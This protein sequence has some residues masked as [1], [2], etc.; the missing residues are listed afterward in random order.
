MGRIKKGAVEKNTTQTRVKSY[1]EILA[2]SGEVRFSYKYLDVSHAKF[3]IECQSPDYFIKLIDRLANV[4]RMTVNE[5]RQ[6]RNNKSMR[7]HS[8]K[9]PEVTEDNFGIPN[10]DEIVTEPWQFS[11]TT[12]EHG[13]IHGFIIGNTFFVRWLDPEHKLYKSSK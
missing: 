5:L 7:S 1:K 12:N 3:C 13:R 11:V 10:E 2:E 6:P 9:W 4:S 8:I